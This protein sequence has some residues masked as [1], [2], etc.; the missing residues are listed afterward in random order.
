MASQHT[1]ISWSGLAVRGRSALPAGALILLVAAA[2][3]LAIWP[4]QSQ[5]LSPALRSAGPGQAA[6]S[7]PVAVPVVQPQEFEALSPQEAE[8]R[9]A[10]RPLSNRPL[11]PARAFQFPAASR[12]G[13]EWNRAVNC[14]ALANYFE[15]AG[16]GPAG[17]RAV[18]Q[19][20]LNRVRHPAFPKSVCEVVFQGAERTTGCQFTFACDGSLARAPIPALFTRAR[21]IAAAALRGSVDR[22]IG[23]ATHYHTRQVVPYWADNLDKVQVRGAH[24]FYV[25]KGRAGSRG[26]FGGLYAGEHSAVADAYLPADQQPGGPAAAPAAATEVFAQNLPMAEGAHP[27]GANRHRAYLVADEGGKSLLAD[28]Q[29]RGRLQAQPLVHLNGELGTP[30][31]N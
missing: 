25:W 24:I 21:E 9:N 27:G 2:L 5:H 28:D 16:E 19:V 20:V 26:A 11:E 12:D 10:A 14:L 31:P 4:R 3:L 30:D 7:E 1:A 22:A 6:V 23:M 13:L 29:N 15:A 17:M 18:S 8:A